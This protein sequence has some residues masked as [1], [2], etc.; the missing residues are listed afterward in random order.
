MQ[1]LLAT[2][3]MFM[4]LLLTAQSGPWDQNTEQQM[5][6][7]T[8]END[9]NNNVCDC[10]N[11]ISACG[12]D[13]CDENP[14]NPSDPVPIDDYIPLLVVIAFAFILYNRSRKNPVA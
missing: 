8:A 4:A 9:V 10:E 12:K 7:K 14:A 5:V 6:Y 11:N 13:D 2:L 1:K 3:C